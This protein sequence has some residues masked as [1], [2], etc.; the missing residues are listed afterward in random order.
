M[1]FTSKFYHAV[2]P[3]IYLNGGLLDWVPSIIYSGIILNKNLSFNKSFES[4]IL[5]LSKFVGV[6]YAIKNLLL[7]KI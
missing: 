6:F 2:L 1:L 5:S 4:I 3:N 7:L